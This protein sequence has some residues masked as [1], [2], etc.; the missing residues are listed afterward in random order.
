MPPDTQQR[1]P[2]PPA[3][4]GAHWQ[5][6]LNGFLQFLGD[7]EGDLLAR[8][9]LDRLAGGRVAAHA[10]GAL[11]H[12]ENAE[13]ADANAVSLLQ[14]LGDQA[15]E[16]AEDCL[17]LLLRHLMIFRELRRQVPHRDGRLLARGWCFGHRLTSSLSG[18]WDILEVTIRRNR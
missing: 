11:S 8:L 12:L 15:D 9:D 16:I 7:A 10:G 14:V 1:F 17:G 6:P 4:G 13:P 2:A 18:L 5:Q 3:T